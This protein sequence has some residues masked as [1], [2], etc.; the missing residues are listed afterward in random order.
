MQRKVNRVE[1]CN[2]NTLFLLF[3]CVVCAFVPWRWDRAVQSLAE[4]HGRDSTLHARVR[5]EVSSVSSAAS[6][7]LSHPSSVCSAP[8]CR[9]MQGESIYS[10]HF[11]LSEDTSFVFFPIS[12][13]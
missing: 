1:R 12:Y 8:L 6:C 10:A 3:A 13:F 2:P 5:G 4:L 11:C 7:K 9:F